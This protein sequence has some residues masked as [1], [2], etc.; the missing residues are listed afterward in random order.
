M[1]WKCLD[2]V[3][4]ITSVR[5]FNYWLILAK[6]CELSHTK[7]IAMKTADYKIVINNNQNPLSGKVKYKS[8]HNLKEICR[9]GVQIRKHYWNEHRYKELMNLKLRLSRSEGL[10]SN[11]K[12]CRKKSYQGKCFKYNDWE[13]SRVKDKLSLLIQEAQHVPVGGGGNT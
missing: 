7:F 9:A 5:V 4:S 12:I 1:P 3:A 8:I 13:I 2:V 11:I 6:I 10:K